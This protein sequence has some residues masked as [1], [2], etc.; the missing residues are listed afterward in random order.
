MLRRSSLCLLVLFLIVLLAAVFVATFDANRYRDQIQTRLSSVLERPVSLGE[1]R[2]SLRH[3][4]AFAFSQVKI[5]QTASLPW[6]LAAERLFVKLELRPL[7]TGRIAFSEIILTKPHLLLELNS[8]QTQSPPA[9]ARKH[10]VPAIRS[11]TVQN[12]TM[13]VEDRRHPDRPVVY[14]LGA[15]E[16]RLLDLAPGRPAW[17]TL[18]GH[19][20]QGKGAAIF[21]LAGELTPAPIWQETG[22]HFGVK[23]D[24]LDPGAL[25][26]PYA[27]GTGSGE[28]KLSLGATL[29]GSPADGL[30]FAGQ[31][32]G[33]DLTVSLP[34]W[35]RQ[36]IPVRQLKVQGTWTENSSGHRLDDLFLEL[37]DL[38]CRGGI[39]WQ[40]RGAQLWL[41]INLSTSP[42]P[43]ADLL[44]RVPDLLAPV[45]VW[46][47]QI[48]EG[49]LEI[50]SLH[51]AGLA[52]ALRTPAAN[53]PLQAR[54]TIRDLAWQSGEQRLSGI[55]FSTLLD[56][57][58][59]QAE[60]RGNY[61]LDSFQ[62]TAAMERPFGGAREVTAELLG[63]LPSDELLAAIPAANRPEL[64]AEGPVPISIFVEG[65]PERLL[66]DIHSDLTQVNAGWKDLL[67]KKS[68]IP[69]RLFLTGELTPGRLEL[70]H[71][72]VQIGRFDLRARGARERAGKHGFSLVL[73][74]PDCP[75]EALYD[76]L[77]L[78]AKLQASGEIALHY[79]MTGA[80]GQA[81]H[82]RGAIRLHDVGLHLTRAIADIRQ[83]SGTLRLTGDRLEIDQLTARLGDSPVQVS[84]FLPDL[85][86]PRADLRVR[87]KTIRADE[88]IFPS[89]RMVL[90]DVDG[91]LLIDR[92]GIEF[93]PTTV[94]LDGGTRASVRGKVRFPP[95]PAVDLDIR[96]DQANI[97][98]IIALWQRTRDSRHSLP[99]GTTSLIT[100]ISARVGAGT[101]RGLHFH[102]AEGNILY[103]QGLLTIAPLHFQVGPGICQ[104]QVSLERS[105]GK[106]LLRVSGHL[107][108][109]DAAAVYK[110]LLKKRRLVTGALS[111]DFYLEGRIG[112]EFLPT[113]LGAFNLA[114]TQGVLN[115]FQV[116]GKVFSLLNISQ[117]LTLQ[118]PDMAREGM[119]FNRLDGTFTLRRGVLAT[120]D[121]FVDSDAMN[122]SLVGQTDLQ[123][124]R[125]DFILGVKPLRTVDKIITHIPVAGWILA[126]E[127]KALITAHFHISGPADNP[128]V[129]PVPITSVSEKVLG[130]FR[131]VLGLPGKM[132]EDAGGLIHGD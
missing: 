3:G 10:A 85:A 78:L 120:E 33:D 12:G 98:E 51:F 111:G 23:V 68:G 41:E 34:A 63:T 80:E 47:K 93:A 16:G 36:P 82:R 48:T 49:S 112:G 22:V 57:D 64:T 43:V 107:E 77:P 44:T 69:G 72:R 55:S 1:A 103:R 65:K 102:Q 66:F 128:D 130:I 90:R 73:D 30:K 126:G 25:W 88:L 104:G 38:A 27:E 53:I 60:G 56:A 105:E 99:S 61:L 106:P 113:S 62:F 17:L 29:A 87:G 110:E 129:I 89:G 119:P 37:D 31:V 97:D 15:L 39:L 9:V 4:L 18:A 91:H 76:H 5:P 114:V 11:L 6:S 125:H 26:A 122:L 45:Q 94:R 59:L 92:T 117:I 58:L 70:S 96:A 46:K 14:S 100:R 79:E 108:D 81:P 40:Q 83:A 109:V 24:G 123:A 124:S 28:G 21:S 131:R 74:I 116:L 121:L 54:F 75:L 7:L 52:A 115:K 86:N 13:D 50:E 35:Y 95:H 118:L 132:I 101:L 67:N 8:A 19:L 32:T 20:Q 71:A 42:L 127:E 2:V 84:G